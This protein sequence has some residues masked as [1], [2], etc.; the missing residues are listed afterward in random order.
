M[1][2]MTIVAAALPLLVA[3]APRSISD[4]N[5]DSQG[6]GVMPHADPKTNDWKVAFAA[7][8]DSGDV[9]PRALPET[10]DWRVAFAALGNSSEAH[11]HEVLVRGAEDDV[12]QTDVDHM[13]ELLERRDDKDH[14]TFSPPN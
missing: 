14:C 9:R 13:S 1:K 5:G 11:P 4:N 8:K 12:N 6:G 10:S 7:L 3:A 2:F